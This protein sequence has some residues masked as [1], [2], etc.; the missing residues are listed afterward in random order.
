M[1]PPLPLVR[2]LKE[3]ESA[4][5][6]LN[7]HDHTYR[8]LYRGQGEQKSLLPSLFRKLEN[9]VDQIKSIEACTLELLKKTVPPSTPQ[10]PKNDWD[11]LSFGQHFRLPTRLLDWSSEQLIALYF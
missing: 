8:R 3:F 9:Q 10:R 1:T 7:E 11:W 4:C 5:Q 2:T 6:K